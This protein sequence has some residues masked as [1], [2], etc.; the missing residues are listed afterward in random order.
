MLK[1]AVDARA[2]ERGATYWVYLG[3]IPVYIGPADS[4]HDAIELAKRLRPWLTQYQLEAHNR[5]RPTE[6]T[7]AA[8]QYAA[9]CEFPYD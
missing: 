3:H 7:T 8:Q 4:E 6:P 1:P 5:P 2:S 9:Y